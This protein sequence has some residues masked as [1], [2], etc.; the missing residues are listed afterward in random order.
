MIE[1]QERVKTAGRA[2]GGVGPPRLTCIWP[3]TLSGWPLDEGEA[4]SCH[5][6]FGLFTVGATDKARMIG[7]LL[8]SREERIFVPSL[9]WIFDLKIMGFWVSGS[10]SGLG[11]GLG[12]GFELSKKQ[13]GFE[14]DMI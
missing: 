8:D 3:H 7:K 5:W 11:L 6:S 10:H 13:R 1:R 12:F 14:L 2:H 4:R 9:L